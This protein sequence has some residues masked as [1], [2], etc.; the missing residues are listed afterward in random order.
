MSF[1]RYLASWAHWATWLALG[2][3]PAQA[4]FQPAGA[5]PTNA[6]PISEW[7][8]SY[9][10]AAEL[11]WN[12]YGDRLQRKEVIPEILP[13]E[14]DAAGHWG[15][16]TNGLQLSLRFRQAEFARGEPVRAVLLLRNL[17]ATQQLITYFP[18]LASGFHYRIKHGTN[19][20][21]W[22]PALPKREDGGGPFSFSRKLKPHTEAFFTEPLET[23]FDLKE[24]GEYSIVAERIIPSKG[25]KEHDVV[26]GEA[27]FRIV[28]T[29]ANS[30][31]STNRNSGGK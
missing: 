18:D 30:N 22:S 9:Q 19:T 17:C 23:F 20:V 27:T 25:L 10:S 15:Q 21:A 24:P 2:A 29:A 4:Q 1:N 31:G 13:A 26:S 16:E 14:Q 6:Y 3:L 28:E 11:E 7:V 12:R 8:R 5:Q